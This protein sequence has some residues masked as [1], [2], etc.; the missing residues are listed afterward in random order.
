MSR[1][2]L[3]SP[4]LAVAV[5]AI[6]VA[7]TGSAVGASLITGKQV[8][9]SSITG[10]DI[11]N[12]SLS[13]ADFRGSVAG[14]RGPQGFTGAQGPVGPQGPAGAPATQSTVSYRSVSAS[15]TVP[16]G[17]IVHVD[18]TCPAGYVLS[19]GGFGVGANDVVYASS[20]SAQTYELSA[21]NGSSIANAS[22]NAQ[23]FC[24]A[25]VTQ[26]AIRSAKPTTLAQRHALEAEFM[27]RLGK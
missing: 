19:G 25:G 13:S 9:D 26:A 22:A 23:A 11:K 16:Q 21:Y 15:G 5:V 12:K 20:T 8:K 18:A 7:S 2:R 14:P 6:V 1:F 24:I 17:Q 10:A 27:A 4:S 3:P